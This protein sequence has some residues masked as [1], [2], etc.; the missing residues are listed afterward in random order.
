MESGRNLM[1]CDDDG[2]SDPYVRV[3]IFDQ[4]QVTNYRKQTLNPNWEED[5]LFIIPFEFME[6]ILH[7]EEYSNEFEE[8][9]DG[10]GFLY[11]GGRGG[12][13]GGTQRGVS[14]AAIDV[15]SHVVTGLSM[16]AYTQKA[17]QEDLKK[18]YNQDFE[19]QVAGSQADIA[20]AM[21][22]GQPGLMK[23]ATTDPS[24]QSS[25]QILSDEA[26]HSNANKSHFGNKSGKLS[27]RFRV[28]DH[29]IDDDDDF[30]GSYKSKIVMKDDT[31]N[32]HQKMITHKL[33]NNQQEEDF[34]C[35]VISYRI[36]LNAVQIF[37]NHELH[38]IDKD[39]E[40]R[41]IELFHTEVK[42]AQPV[43]MADVFQM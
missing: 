26:A 18:Q 16:P 7:V 38:Y 14:F 1:A 3:S 6:R 27:I 24:A 41:P 12:D 8:K 13:Q 15:D 20:S 11:G 17:I 31:S 25:G 2:K 28:F 9:K 30:M 22:S 42:D 29:D 21:A 33:Q 36:Y 10:D 34:D 4:Q 39:I 37:Q 32:Y 23:R 35:G 43:Q 19:F 40:D 5:L